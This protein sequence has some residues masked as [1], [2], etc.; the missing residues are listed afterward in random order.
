MG[1]F[2]A[3]R[4][5]W[6]DVAAIIDPLVTDD[7][8][9]PPVDSTRPDRFGFVYLLKSGKHYKI[10]HTFDVGRRKYELAIQLPE[11][12]QL[13]HE[14]RTD[15]PVGIERYWHQRFEDCRL[16]GEWFQLSQAD[17]AAFRRRKFM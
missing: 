6:S 15:D 3:E 7:L 12:V 9:P 13:Q 11:P 2:C 14:I 17:V 1:A 16:N 5:E 4:P 8:E 10:G